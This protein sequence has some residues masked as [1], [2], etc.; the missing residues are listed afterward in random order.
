M[1]LAELGR[2]ALA[3]LVVVLVVVTMAMVATVAIPVSPAWRTPS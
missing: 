2:T 1:S 3:G